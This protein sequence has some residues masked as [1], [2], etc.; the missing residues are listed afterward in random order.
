LSVNRISLLGN[1]GKDPEYKTLASGDG[2]CRLS[3][4]TSEVFN[5]RQ[6]AKQT[7]KMWHQIVAY[8]KTAELCHK[9]LS[10][11]RQVFLE[12]KITY[13]TY[14]PEGGAKQYICE[15]VANHVTFLGGKDPDSP[16]VHQAPVAAPPQ[17]SQPVGDFKGF[18]KKELP[19]FAS[20]SQP[21]YD[22]EDIP[23]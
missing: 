11:G 15:I 10:K 16:E 23:F 21:I 6:G 12:G 19:K 2:Y 1:L 20:T 3:L 9:Y 18:A 7:R 5:D 22:Q 17:K 8:G 4:C 14:E 13:R